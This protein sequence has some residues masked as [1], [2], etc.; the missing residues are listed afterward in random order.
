MFEKISDY[1][2]AALDKIE[3]FLYDVRIL[4]TMPGGVDERIVIVD[5]DE[6]SLAEVGR[7]PWS[8]IHIAKLLDELFDNYD[9]TLVGFDVVFP[10][11]D[12]SSG[13]RILQ[14]LG[15]NELADIKKYHDALANLED[16]LDYD[17]K[18]SKSITDHPVV[19]GYYF[20]DVLSSKGST[21]T[22]ELPMPAFHRDTF[23]NKN[24]QA[25]KA[26]GYN[27]NIKELQDAALTAGHFSLPTNIHCPVD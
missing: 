6:K 14:K 2:S 26:I 16:Q 11:P 9:V 20:S 15:R 24:V 10:E 22:G 3:N 23:E 12:N 4:M 18:L 7:W 8:R 19:L 13:L 1:N 17:K 25:R 21:N 27:A 5:I